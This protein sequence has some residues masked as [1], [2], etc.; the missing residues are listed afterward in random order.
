[1]TD[2]THPLLDTHSVDPSTGE[3]Y[4]PTPLGTPHDGPS[5]NLPSDPTEEA[6]LRA[7]Y[8]EEFAAIF[9]ELDEL[10]RSLVNK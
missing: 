5:D 1:M 9:D 8:R 3:S 10:N 7:Q 4:P 2:D 6:R